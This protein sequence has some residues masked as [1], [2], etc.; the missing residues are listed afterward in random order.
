MGTGHGRNQISCVSLAAHAPLIANFELRRIQYKKNERNDMNSF[1]N[2]S[3]ID[4]QELQQ[5][6]RMRRGGSRN[7]IIWLKLHAFANATT[8][9]H[10]LPLLE[11]TDCGKAV[12]HRQVLKKKWRILSV[13]LKRSSFK[14]SFPFL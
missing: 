11:I 3:T 1:P 6:Q 2:S 4:F 7:S 9:S 10:H 5:P 13:S 14:M 8:F 12:M